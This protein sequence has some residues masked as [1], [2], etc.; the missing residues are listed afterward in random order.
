[1]GKF[2]FLFVMQ[3]VCCKREVM[4][5]TTEAKVVVRV[6]RACRVVQ[7]PSAKG[8]FFLTV[9]RTF[10]ELV[11]RNLGFQSSVPLAWSEIWKNMRRHIYRVRVYISRCSF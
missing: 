10:C 1:M 5:E 9:D 8:G 3:G 6:L 2:I 4:G 11:R 7:F